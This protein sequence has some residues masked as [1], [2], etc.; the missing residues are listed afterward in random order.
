MEDNIWGTSSYSNP[1]ASAF[2]SFQDP[3]LADNATTKDTSDKL[4]LIQSSL[5]KLPNIASDKV[6]QLQVPW[7][8]LVNLIADK[9]RGEEFTTFRSILQNIK[10]VNDKSITGVALIHYVIAFDRANYI[11][12]LYQNSHD[13]PNKANLDL[14]L[15]DDLIGYSPLMWTFILERKDCSTEL[16]YFSNDIDFGQINK[17][18]GLTAW[19][20][21][22]PGSTMYTFLSE[23]N[24]LQY[25]NI[26]SFAENDNKLK[27]SDDKL[28]H[29]AI[30]NIDIQ[31]AGMGL[32]GVSANE[33][34]ST[35][36][37]SSDIYIAKNNQMNTFEYF[38][39]T[40]LVKYQYFEIADYD[41]PQILDLLVSL[42]TEKQHMTTYPAA[43]LFQCIR[44]ADH[45]KKSPRLVESLCHLSFTKIVSSIANDRPNT[46]KTKNT[47]EQK[48]LSSSLSSTVPLSAPGDETNEKDDSS[49]DKSNSAS[50]TKGDIMTQ[51]YWIGALTFLYYYLSKDDSF[52]KRY[53]SILQELI[54]TIH[55]VMIELTTSIHSRLSPLIEPT[56][57][58]YTTISDVE[59][60][61][62]KKDWNFFKKRKQTKQLKKD[63]LKKMEQQQQ[64]ERK[65]I[66]SFEKNVTNNDNATNNP[67]SP[68]TTKTSNDE[69]I[70]FDSEV[71]KH[72][73]PPS[74]E[75]Q[76]KPSP[77]K[78]VQIFGALSYVLNLHQI[79]H[80][81][82]QQC[83]S[84]ATSWFSTSFFNMILKD[85]KKKTLSRAR[86]I[87]IRLN[88]SSL[89]S[90]IKNN[91]LLVPKPTLI[92]DF[93]WERFPYTLVQ[94][95]NTIDM[96]NPVLKNVTT[97]K[98]ING[99][100]QSTTVTD[101]TNSL[102]YYQKFHRIAQ[103]H[104]EPLLELLQW[105]QIATTLDTEEALENTKELLPKLSNFQLIKAI[106]KYHYEVNEH[107]FNSKLKKFLNNEIKQFKLP[108][109]VYLDENQIPLLTLPTLSE[110][111]DIYANEYDY[112]PLL[113]N[114]IQDAMYEIH[115]GNYKLRFNDN[116]ISN[117]I[118]E[119]DDEDENSNDTSNDN[120]IDGIGNSDRGE[121]D[122][123]N[124]LNVPSA[125]ASRPVWANSEETEEN[126]W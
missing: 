25:K 96:S 50:S 90:W 65:S 26:Q 86:A 30:N 23:N 72:L 118:S 28:N 35:I 15:I 54:N 104:L 97:Y 95:L 8:E 119:D 3:S 102:F 99:F 52:F 16:F 53:P 103:L 55:S 82:Q 108:E 20:M 100:D 6:T 107:K 47:K 43:L 12:L 111:S 94:E 63:K 74:L 17:E 44:F 24:M 76:M 48:N 29:D 40:K 59:Q 60:T 113:P 42:P 79:H 61:L 91:D 46:D 105:L 49:N 115:D 21:V 110:L 5:Y 84:L 33:G 27:K 126:P 62:Y 68:I 98:P 22:S 83:L 87:Q 1:T 89:E 31:L 13:S 78:V 70:F 36:D 124:E 125:A 39:F 116:G 57:I 64:K 109:K 77:M 4:G 112:L 56:L 9:D 11:E 45:K 88:L 114:D 121:N 41:I 71:L 73:L 66:D 80:L 37:A 120:T 101:T 19:D 18:N 10:D 123:F 92:D 122:I 34:F 32:A 7:I 51:S 58:N 81:F 106:D 85:R 14:N 93:M 117:R 38:D 75:E 67:L 69:S 2:S